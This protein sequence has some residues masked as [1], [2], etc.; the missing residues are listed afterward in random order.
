MNA[1]HDPTTTLPSNTAARPPLR[2]HLPSTDM[3]LKGVVTG[4][5]VS[6]IT[7]TGRNLIKVMAK[8]PAIMLGLG[9]LTGYWAHKHRRKLLRGAAIAAHESK[10][11]L[12][13]QREHLRG[14]DEESGQD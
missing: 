6:T 3:L 8:N 7:Q 4:V 12:L 14:A 10:Q 2:S 9:V 1:K 13:R 5:V 11:F